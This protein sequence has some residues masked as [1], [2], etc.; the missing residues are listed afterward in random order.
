M[1]ALAAQNAGMDS[2]YVREHFNVS[3]PQ[4]SWRRAHDGTAGAAPKRRGPQPGRRKFPK[5]M[6]R[7]LFEGKTAPNAV[8]LSQ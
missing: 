4:R 8:G 2:A 5:S 6:T 1:A 7:S 3:I